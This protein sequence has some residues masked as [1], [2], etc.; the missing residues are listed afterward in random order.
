MLR[1]LERLRHEQQ[2][3][4][5]AERMQREDQDQPYGAGSGDGGGGGAHGRHRGASGWRPRSPGSQLPGGG[6]GRAPRDF[7]GYY[8]LLGVDLSGAFRGMT[9]E[10]ETAFCNTY[11]M[12]SFV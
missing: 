12:R 5:A 9:W 6:S 10:E 7:L 3:R 2:Q 8:K 1:P 11:E 4:E